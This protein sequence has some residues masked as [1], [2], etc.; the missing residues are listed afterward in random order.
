[1][2]TEDPGNVAGLEDTLSLA[3]SRP[4]ELQPERQQRIGPYRLL[5]LIGEGGMGEVWVAEQLEPVRRRVAVKVIKA[6]MDTKQVIARFEAER[7]A[8]ALMDHGAIAK[9]LD[10]GATAEGRPYFVMEYVAGVPITEHCDSHKLSTE[11]RLR[12]LI[13]VCEGVQHAHQKAIIH[14]DLKPSNILVSLVDGH[15]QPKIIDFGIAKATGYRLTEKTL[16][17][18]LGAVIG[19]PEYMSPEQADLTGQDVDTRT[20]VYSL[21]VILYQ[22]LTGGLPFG[23][24]EL[25]SS[26]YEELRRKL[27]EV[28]PPRPSARLSTTDPEAVEAARNRDTDPGGLQ[29]ELEGDL[30]AITMK[31]L[32][33]DRARRYGTPSE[34]AADIERYLHHEPVLAQTPSRAYRF[35]KYARRHRA[36]LTSLAAVVASLTV[37]VVATTFGFF[38]A[39]RA[40]AE[41]VR[42]QALAEARLRSA[43]QYADKLFFEI[44]PEIAELPGATAVRTKLGTAGSKLV[45]SLAIGAQDDP[46]LRWQ[47]ARINLGLSKLQGWDYG[48]GSL[49]D[50][51]AAIRSGER[52]QELLRSLPPDFPTRKEHNDAEFRGHDYLQ[53]ALDRSGR[54]D[55]A[56]QHLDRM[57]ELARSTQSETDRLEM[58]GIA[59]ARRAN[60]LWKKGN[61]EEAVAMWR[62]GVREFDSEAP[63]PAHATVVQ[64]HRRSVSHSI[65]GGHLLEIGDL[66]SAISHLRF[67]LQLDQ[68]KLKK[69][70]HVNRYARDLADDTLRLGLALLHQG[71]FAEGERLLQEGVERFAVMAS[72]DPAN[73]LIQRSYFNSL[74]RA[75]DHLFTAAQEKRLPTDQRR[76]FLRS[77]IRYWEQ[78]RERT[79]AAVSGQSQA[80]IELAEGTPSAKG[81]E[82]KMDRSAAGSSPEDCGGE[83]P[84]A[85]H[86]LL[87]SLGSAK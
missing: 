39:R 3:H 35:R 43:Q 10:G 6:G 84:H 52:A 22:L 67:A 26:S 77:A 86:A 42:Q 4:K 46:Q 9:V 69:A 81:S 78:C 19:T 64:L 18:E 82:E 45:E 58:A 50:Y 31:A 72:G 34:L 76:R 83:Q 73:A 32:E 21:G 70:P 7:Q 48:G 62:D 87:V 59:R 40:R 66:D 24:K 14:R 16:F 11:E 47:T 44:A 20:D 60:V 56:L 57:D 15:G 85:A 68:L 63:D 33:K 61:R 71:H 74:D 8:L 41:A 53:G 2:A 75:A 36:L 5:Q 27:R 28:E 49:R 54:F 25:R 30:D 13:E 12:L 37:G 38:E 55:E 51:T 23:S 80:G 1:M 65:L 17:T 79:P 29:R